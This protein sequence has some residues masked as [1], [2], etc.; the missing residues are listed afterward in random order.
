MAESVWGVA[1]NFRGSVDPDLILLYVLCPR[2]ADSTGR[3]RCACGTA[4]QETGWGDEARKVVT[5]CFQNIFR[6]E[7]RIGIGK[8]ASIPANPYAGLQPGRQLLPAVQAGRLLRS[9]RWPT[10][11]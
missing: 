5:A 10:L 3:S 6:S 8:Q 11:R 4:G 2:V 1:L 9:I 7:F